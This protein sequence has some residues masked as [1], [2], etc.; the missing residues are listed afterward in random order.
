MRVAGIVCSEQPAVVLARSSNAQVAPGRK[1]GF[2]AEMVP[3]VKS[4]ARSADH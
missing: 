2:R 3:A 4:T 1:N